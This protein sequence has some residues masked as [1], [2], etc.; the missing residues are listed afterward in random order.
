[1]GKVKFTNNNFDERLFNQ[2]SIITIYEKLTEDNTLINVEAGDFMCINSERYGIDQNGDLFPAR[3]RIYY[4]DGYGLIYDTYSF[5]SHSHPFI[6][7]TIG[8]L[9]HSI[10]S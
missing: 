9:Y 4:S 8:F 1:M 2:F 3:D 7:R 5:L 10:A 6:I